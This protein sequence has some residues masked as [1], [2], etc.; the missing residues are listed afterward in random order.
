MRLAV[1]RW[2]EEGGLIL[3]VEYPNHDVAEGRQD[4]KTLLAEI[5]WREDSRDREHPA[6]P[7]VR[8]RSFSPKQPLS[9][10]QAVLVRSI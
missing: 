10:A 2:E 5:N 1:E 7:P 9:C 4:A 8:R 6:S 3:P